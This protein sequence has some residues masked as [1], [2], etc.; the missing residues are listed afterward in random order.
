MDTTTGTGFFSLYA[1]AMTAAIYG[2][3]W[4]GCFY[5]PSFLG[6][7]LFPEQIVQ[8]EMI[9]GIIVLP[10]GLVVLGAFDGIRI[11]GAHLLLAL[12]ALAA[13]IGF[14]LATGRDGDLEFVR[15]LILIVLFVSYVIAGIFAG[16]R[17]LRRASA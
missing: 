15:R 10:L 9:A 14:L 11:A 17:R 4:F 8:I 6:Y 5:W 13:G 3:T 7:L 16:R 1:T 12:L 2:C